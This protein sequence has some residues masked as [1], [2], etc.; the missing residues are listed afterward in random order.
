[1]DI[2]KELKGDIDRVERTIVDL[3]NELSLVHP[4]DLRT[5]KDL[6]AELAKFES[7]LTRKRGLLHNVKQDYEL[8][9][10]EIR[11]RINK[12]TGEGEEVE[13]M[14]DVYE[15]IYERGDLEDV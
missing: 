6:Y 7:E 5:R 2:V 9:N 4:E 12:L 1:M 10:D 3:A 15:D 11:A 14:F 8:K 13:D